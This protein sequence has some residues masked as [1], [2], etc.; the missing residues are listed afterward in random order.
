[1][2]PLF[3]SFAFISSI[4]TYNSSYALDTKQK[5]SPYEAAVQTIQQTMPSKV[6]IDGK[7]IFSVELNHECMATVIMD[8][9]RQYPFMLNEWPQKGKIDDS[10]YSAFVLKDTYNKPHILRTDPIKGKKY[11]KS[12][13][14]LISNCIKSLKQKEL[15]QSKEQEKP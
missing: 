6:T 10:G 1:M 14:F 11:L 5:P 13:D 3:L 4:F 7:R 2:K 15:S 12:I 9:K 8:P